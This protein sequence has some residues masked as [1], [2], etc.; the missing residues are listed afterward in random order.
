MSKLLKLFNK[1]NN[2][3]GEYIQVIL[4]SRVISEGFSISHI[5]KVHIATGHWNYSETDQAIA[6]SFREFSHVYLYEQG[7]LQKRK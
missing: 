6:R 7:R 1:P 2:I 5:Q 4:G 3:Y